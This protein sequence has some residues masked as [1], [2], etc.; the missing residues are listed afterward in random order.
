MF[1]FLYSLKKFL[2]LTAHRVRNNSITTQLKE[3]RRLKQ[4]GLHTLFSM[5]SAA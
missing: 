5:L 4:N 3:L 2:L 1:H